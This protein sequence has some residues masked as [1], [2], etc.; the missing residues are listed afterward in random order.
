M[1]HLRLLR[2]LKGVDKNG[3]GN[4]LLME[5]HYNKF[6]GQIVRKDKFH[7][8]TRIISSLSK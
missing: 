1:I 5:P 8:I 4:Y 6:K 3:P 7:F 2:I